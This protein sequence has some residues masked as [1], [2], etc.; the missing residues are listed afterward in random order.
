MLG[1]GSHENHTVGFGGDKMER[2]FLKYNE[3][4]MGEDALTSAGWTKSASCDP[5]IGY[6]WSQSGKQATE[7][8]PLVLYTTSSGQ[9]SGVG[10]TMYYHAPPDKQMKYVTGAK[11]TNG[12]R[13]DVAFRKGP[14]ICA[15]SCPG[16]LGDTLIVNPGAMHGNGGESKELSLTQADAES[17]GWHRGSCFDGMGTHSFFD[18]TTADSSM[19][20]DAE[21]LFP[22]VAMYHQGQINAIFFASWSIQ[23][24]L[25]NQNQWEPAPLPNMAMCQNTCDSDCTFSG[26]S[27]W[28]TLHV[29]FRDHNE[30]QCDRSLSCAIPLGHMSCCPKHDVLV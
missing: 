4:P 3:L 15:G 30:V 6:M 7:S 26:T 5:A 20:W 14:C 22:V 29:Y 21:N 8:K 17:Q 27:M 16:L 2:T 13:I 11:E 28:S 23:Q 10:V 9:P 25:F 19:S 1:L 24:G 12:W 18:T